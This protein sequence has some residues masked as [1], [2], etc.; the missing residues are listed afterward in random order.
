MKGEMEATY[1]C[2]KVD[3]RKL[4]SFLI[5]GFPSRNISSPV[6]QRTFSGLRKLQKTQKDQRQPGE[7]LCF[8]RLRWVP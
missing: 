4:L 5:H 3:E 7:K 6:S 1:S 8:F 2:E